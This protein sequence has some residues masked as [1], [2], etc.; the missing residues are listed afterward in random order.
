MECGCACHTGDGMAGHDDLCCEI[1]NGLI[2][3]NP[4]KRL[5]SAKYY[6]DIMN[7]WEEECE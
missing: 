2:K 1:P 3:N 4:Y 7:K 5:R 6:L